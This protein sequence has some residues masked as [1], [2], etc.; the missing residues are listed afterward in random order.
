VIPQHPVAEGEPGTGE[1]D[2]LVNHEY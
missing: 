2:N 1:R